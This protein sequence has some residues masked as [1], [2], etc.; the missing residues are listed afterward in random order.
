MFVRVRRVC[1]E[2]WLV[3]AAVAAP[4]V[5]TEAHSNFLALTNV[6]HLRPRERLHTL[7]RRETNDGG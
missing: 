4:C 2:A 1:L 3:A 7:R 6:A 5:S